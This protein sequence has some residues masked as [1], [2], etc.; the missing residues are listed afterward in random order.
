[1]FLSMQTYGHNVRNIGKCKSIIV[2]GD[3]KH[4]IPKFWKVNFIFAR[5]QKFVFYRWRMVRR[6]KRQLFLSLN[7]VDI[8]MLK[9]TYEKL[10][11]CSIR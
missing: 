8:P 5:I 4:D 1:M 3:N 10:D 9:V 7:I 11:I 6:I 2:T